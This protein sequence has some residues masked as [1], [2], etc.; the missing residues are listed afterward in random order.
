MKGK[1]TKLLVTGALLA[2]LGS[3]YIGNGVLFYQEIAYAQEANEVVSEDSF[4][5]GNVSIDDEKK[6]VTWEL[7]LS[8]TASEA[9]VQKQ[10]L[11]GL[12][13][14]MDVLSITDN[15]GQAVEQDSK[16]RY[17]IGTN[18][19]E[20]ASYSISLVTSL[21][22]ETNYTFVPEIRETVSSLETDVTADVSL[23]DETANTYGIGT[24]ET[25]AHTLALKQ[26]K[27]AVGL[28]V[29]NNKESLLR[30]ETTVSNWAELKNSVEN[31][32]DDVIYLTSYSS[33]TT[34]SA[35][36]VNRDVTI[37]SRVSDGSTL[38]SNART[39]FN[40]TAGNSLS[41]ENF[42]ISGAYSGYFVTVNGAVAGSVKNTH[43][44]LSSFNSGT[45][46]VAN[47]AGIVSG[48][49]NTYNTTSVSIA[50]S[51]I[52]ST[53]ART[54]FSGLSELNFSGSSQLDFY[55]S[56]AVMFEVGS[57]VNFADN[58]GVTVASQSTTS[59]GNSVI[60]IAD[61][62][63]VVFDG[64]SNLSL[65]RAYIGQL[66]E[67]R[68]SPD[69]TP[70]FETS[71]KINF[72]QTNSTNPINVN[73]KSGVFVRAKNSRV[74]FSAVNIHFDV[75]TDTTISASN[76][77]ASST[78]LLAKAMPLVR[79][80]EAQ[81]ANIKNS[82]FSSTEGYAFSFYFTEV[83]YSELNIASSDIQLN[84]LK[85]SVTVAQSSIPSMIHFYGNED[86]GGNNSYPYRH[87][88]SNLVINNSSVDL[89]SVS[90]NNQ[91]DGS[92]N[93]YRTGVILHEHSERRKSPG[94]SGESSDPT[95]EA[96]K[97]DISGNSQV[98]VYNPETSGIATRGTG[99][100]FN[101][102]GGS[103]LEVTGGSKIADGMNATDANRY[104]AAIRMFGH[105]TQYGI[106]KGEY[107]FNITEA[108][109]F[110]AVKLAGAR[111]SAAM[112]IGGSAN[113]VNV[114]GDS[115]FQLI[116][117]GDGNRTP[118]DPAGT[119]D[120]IALQYDNIPN[121]DTS[122]AVFNVG[123]DGTKDNS[124]VEILAQSGMGVYGGG[125]STTPTLRVYAY[126]D[127]EFIVRGNTT[128]SGT[129]G[130]KYGVFGLSGTS[131][132]FNLYMDQARYYEFE[133]YNKNGILVNANNSGNTFEVK[134]AY[135]MLWSNS[136]T[137]APDHD[138]SPTYTIGRLDYKLT[139]TNF[140]TTSG[141]SGHEYFSSGINQY[142]YVKAQGM[143]GG[144][145]NA[146]YQASNADDKI[147]GQ[148]VVAKRDQNGDAEIIN[149][150][151]QYETLEASSNA[152][153]GVFIEYTN[154]SGTLVRKFVPVSAAEAAW[155][156]TNS[157][158]NFVLDLGSM[159]IPVGSEIRIIGS[160]DRNNY[161]SGD[162]EYATPSDDDFGSFGTVGQ[163]GG[164][165]FKQ[166]VID[167]LA[168]NVTE[169]T[170]TNGSNG[171]ANAT[172]SGKTEPG[173][174][175][176]LLQKT[177]NLA[178]VY[179]TNVDT[180]L[181]ATAD[182][183]GVW[184]ITGDF[185]STTKIYV[186][187]ADQSTFT[188]AQA[189]NVPGGTP[190]GLLLGVAGATAHGTWNGLEGNMTVDSFIDQN[191]ED[192]TLDANKN[193]ISYHAVAEI[194]KA[195]YLNVQ[196]ENQLPE[197][198]IKAET[199]D[200][201]ADTAVKT[202]DY[203]SNVS[204]YLNGTD[205]NSGDYVRQ[206]VIMY[207]SK[208]VLTKNYSQGQWIE[209]DH[210][211]TITAEEL[212]TAGI[213]NDYAAGENVLTAYVYST[214]GSGSGEL[215]SQK[216]NEV[217]LTLTVNGVLMLASAPATVDFGS[218]T[219]NAKVQRVDNPT[220]DADLVVTDTRSGITDGWTLSAALTTNMTNVSTG[221][222][223]NEALWYVDGSGN[224]IPLTLDYGD[225]IIYTST[226]GGSFDVTSTW[227]DTSDEP[228]LKLIADPTKTTVS[229]IG[230]YSG[231][232]TW[233]IMAGQP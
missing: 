63:Q 86:S 106:A 65:D 221:S 184:S 128:T 145:V 192:P 90:Y 166:E 159:G 109:T 69:F 102:S 229:S 38:A 14:T 53:N 41:L 133:N 174:K 19:S 47:G 137:S 143:I 108:S 5:I 30:S 114:T 157:Q 110:R 71:G 79:F 218:L 15:D 209:N 198:K 232:V 68:R 217:T 88:S 105:S 11:L 83:D 187:A 132:K 118:T 12:P 54:T 211:I 190:K 76:A 78:E 171:L 139:G 165:S 181:T 91:M 191:L 153:A 117:E 89:R 122:A 62:G 7:S 98:T 126:E 85:S 201:Y 169:A 152:A 216:S 32:T 99:T 59:V 87:R 204:F 155:G 185:T 195:F 39:R 97:I 167:V 10:L 177:I 158:A 95:P 2:A 36:N 13:V 194:P 42:A 40:V 206:L 176:Y 72:S 73:L 9:A 34:D 50:D 205:S 200:P 60:N 179:P 150:Q 161:Q 140:T 207:G 16:G 46:Y 231:V 113:T 162:P 154:S 25:N 57:T 210:Q 144:Q 21:T 142:S 49:N 213:Y 20:S 131:P 70:F 168:P 193:S 81:T 196:S 77:T 28:S 125:L 101:L 75:N 199:T 226:S 93:L 134:N 170:V 141:S 160:W 4:K 35:I 115:I 138:D 228:G 33:V 27:S 43:I 215:H 163:A 74:D 175:V 64:A 183:S 219:Y 223:M 225:Q 56:N 84:G 94:E 222:V 178:I 224:E 111:Q 148:L 123:T 58:S 92:T 100:Q 172:V 24:A 214:N 164:V 220:T 147:Y 23:Q 127:A 52:F 61:G 208:T 173:A 26:T 51:R 120:Y 45:T 37:I 44:A 48:V 107:Q 96:S 6:T 103:T 121:G 22:S 186:Y 31:G 116:N 112:R 197:L 135:T 189:A 124:K 188:A 3:S 104:M 18:T 55:A 67:L 119:G 203:Y 29:F 212:A 136:L 146:F 227:G 82:T 17:V 66:Q 80:I 230:T 182:A 130:T 233:T 8:K 202:V 180:L 149:D 129:S 156:D 151:V 1:K